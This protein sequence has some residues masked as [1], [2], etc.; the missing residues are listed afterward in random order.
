MAEN[1]VH[2]ISVL[3]LLFVFITICG[4]YLMYVFTV[5]I[6]I[7]SLSEEKWHLTRF[8]H[9]SLKKANSLGTVSHHLSEVL[10][11]R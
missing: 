9:V 5:T 1:S 11:L 6:S 4:S 3:L 8:N 10:L 7:T 2:C